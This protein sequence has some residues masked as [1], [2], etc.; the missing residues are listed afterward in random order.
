MKT[1]EMYLKDNTVITVQVESF[2]LK[3]F[4]NKLNDNNLL[5]INVGGKVYS[6]HLFKVVVEKS[7]LE[8]NTK[9]TLNDMVLNA[10]GE[11]YDANEITKQINDLKN[12][13]TIVGNVVFDKRSF[14]KI[15]Q[16]VA[17]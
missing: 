10:Y 9:I 14:Q 7:D 12:V 4:A 16:I 2:D 13:Y 5:A 15:E 11:Q 3:D 6:K 1:I 8:D 17:A